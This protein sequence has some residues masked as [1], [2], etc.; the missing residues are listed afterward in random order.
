MRYRVKPIGQNAEFITKAVN[1]SSL[2]YRQIGRFQYGTTAKNMGV[3]IT[4]PVP[5]L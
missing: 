4:D 3:K 1:C 5:G 2:H